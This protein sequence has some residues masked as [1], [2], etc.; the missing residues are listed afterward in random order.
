M[1]EIL[2]RVDEAATEQPE[3]A[4]PPDLSAFDFR[5][6]RRYP[7]NVTPVAVHSPD[8]PESFAAQIVNVSKSGLRLRAARS[9]WPGQ[10]VTISFAD[11]KRNKAIRAEAR[12]CN[13]PE[14]GI[15]EIGLEITSFIPATNARR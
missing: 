8:D 15:Y 6:E 12:F 14:D 1:T 4:C 13:S 9:L 3:E 11:A 5:R 10:R 2:H 7:C